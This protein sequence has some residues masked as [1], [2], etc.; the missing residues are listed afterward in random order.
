VRSRHTIAQYTPQGRS[1]VYFPAVS[2]G[3]NVLQTEGAVNAQCQSD[4]ACPQ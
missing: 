4:V 1:L 2:A 3:S